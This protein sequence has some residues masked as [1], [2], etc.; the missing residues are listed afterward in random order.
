MKKTLDKGARLGII[1]FVITVA[2]Y[3][4]EKVS[5]LYISPDKGTGICMAMVNTALTL[6][7][8]FLLFKCDNTFFGLLAGLTAYKMMPMEL[9]FLWSVSQDAD[10]LYYVVQKA[11]LFIFMG[12]IFRIYKLQGK[13]REVQAF[14]VLALMFAVPI[15][16]EIGNKFMEYFLNRT[17]SM[18]FGYFAQFACYIAVSLIILVIAWYSGYTSM[19]FTAYFEFAAV[20]INLLRYVGRVAVN[21]MYHNHVSKSFYIW[22]VIYAA[23]ICLFF[24][25]SRLKKKQENSIA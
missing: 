16:K 6:A 12:L 13:P 4:I 11:A 8:I 19:R 22:I 7:V 9:N 17:G 23:L 15:F 24:I 20:G 1:A 14:P 21:L 2:S 10:M 3:A 18:L 5:L 25:A